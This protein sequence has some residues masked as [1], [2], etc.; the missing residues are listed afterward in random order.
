M[1]KSLSPFDLAMSPSYNKHYVNLAMST[2][3]NVLVRMRLRERYV[4]MAGAYA[5]VR[6]GTSARTPVCAA[7]GLL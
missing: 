7:S 1:G 6:G 5:R 4:C 3:A 2:C